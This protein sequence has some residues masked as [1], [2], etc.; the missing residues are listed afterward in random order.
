MHPLGPGVYF[1]SVNASG[2]L[3]SLFQKKKKKTKWNTRCQRDRGPTAHNSNL[4]MY[5]GIRARCHVRDFT[6]DPDWAFTCSS[7]SGRQCTVRAY[8]EREGGPAPHYRSLFMVISFKIIGLQAPAQ[9][10]IELTVHVPSHCSCI[11]EP[12]S[13]NSTMDSF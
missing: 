7:D 10:G 9:A 13:M 2:F 3:A 8:L 1:L 11:G 12:R 5:G 6:M 4:S